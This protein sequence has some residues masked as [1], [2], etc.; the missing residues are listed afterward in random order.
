MS[1]HSKSNFIIK[2]LFKFLDNHHFNAHHVLQDTILISLSN[3]HIELWNCRK[4][5]K[6]SWLL[7]AQIVDDISIN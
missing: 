1:H 7:G 2:P 3:W 6:K 4:K 5:V